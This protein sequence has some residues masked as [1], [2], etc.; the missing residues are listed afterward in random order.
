[1][2]LLIIHLEE[3]TPQNLVI[4]QGRRAEHLTKVLRVDVNHKLRTGV[5]NGSIGQASIVDLAPDKVTL[6]LDQ[7]S[8]L[9]P[10]EP[11]PC[12]LILAM[13]RPK[14]M[15]RVLQTV[16]AMGVKEVHLINCWKVEKSY[17][18]TP[19]LSEHSIREN[20]IL[21]L[22]QSMDTLLP[23]V[24]IHKLFKPFVEDVLPGL[25]RGKLALAGHPSATDRCPVDLQEPCS[26]IIGPEGGFTEYETK[27]LQEAGV[28][29]VHLGRR[30]LRVE[31]AIPVLL[32]RLY[33]A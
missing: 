18:Q 26:L 5:L 16:A 30:I 31:T 20:L 14:M 8:F 22:E 21:G 24:T 27:K 28:Q 32:S 17:W 4:L 2:N 7:D 3:L 29:A 10:P 1:M 25:I 33:P 6:E 12:Q 19:W 23:S 11:L 15:R 13:P 9:A